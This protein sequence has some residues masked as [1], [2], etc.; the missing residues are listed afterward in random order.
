MYKYYFEKLHVWQ[1]AREFIDEIYLITKSF[2]DDEKYN[3]IS[4]LKRASVSTLVNLAEGSARNTSKDQ[5]HF[6]T[7]SYSSLMEVLA[8][9]TVSK[10]QGFIQDD[11]FIEIRKDLNLI[12][13]QLNALKKAQKRT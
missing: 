7:I 12:A 8:L 13:N 11:K 3:L 2:P 1:N 10:D 5:A 6:T 4:Q 9:L